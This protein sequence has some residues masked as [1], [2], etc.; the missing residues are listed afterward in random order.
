MRY[1]VTLP[2]GREIPVDV[3]HLPTGKI[4]V[5]L[6]G[7]V[8]EVDA[9]GSGASTHLSLEGSGVELWL[10]GAPPEVGVVA[11][12]RRFYARVE[13][14]R[15][16]D[17]HG[18]SKNRGGQGAGLVKSP[19]P[20]RVVKVLVQEGDAVRAGQ[21]LVV[22]EAMKMENELGAERDGVVKKI[23]VAPGA[24]VEGGARLLEVG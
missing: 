19:M 16:R 8:L 17:L 4:Q 2:S 11:G 3:T 9:F 6:E 24:T 21:P 14:E 13:S 22:V 1:F 20:G 12:G 10:E 23:F 18:I 15:T 7:R 5:N